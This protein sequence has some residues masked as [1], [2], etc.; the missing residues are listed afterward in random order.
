M[1]RVLRLK[2]GDTATNNDYLG[3]EGEIVLDN[4][5]HTIV[6]HDGVKQG[7]YRLASE[8][9][10]SLG[11]LTVVDQTIAG[12]NIDGNIIISPDGN[13]RV[14]LSN[15]AYPNTDGNAGQTLITDG[16][17]N[18]YWSTP[19]SVTFSTTAPVSPHNGDIWVD[20]NTGIEYIYY[21][22]DDSSQWVEFGPVNTQNDNI[23]FLALNTN[24]VPAVDSFYDLGT[25]SKQWRSLY[26]SGNT[27]YINQIPLTIDNSQNLLVNGNIIGGSQANLGNVGFDGD[28][29]Y[30]INGI[31][32][33]NNDLAHGGTAWVQIP[34]NGGGDIQAENYY[35]NTI[36]SSSLTGVQAMK[37]WTF[38]GD[39]TL[40]L[41][42]INA[43]GQTNAAWLQTTG[44][45]IANANG[46]LFIF[47]DD[48][49]LQ[50]PDGKIGRAHV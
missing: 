8:G 13:G 5:A 41:P 45:I 37:S 31:R 38:G 10:F 1:I 26:V 40:T 17:G 39:G 33:V 46:A 49:S 18:L 43:S 19:S 23:N 28:N 12:T 14:I 3:R 7:G 11:N 42:K 47:A 2:R 44:N 27:I 6:I 9:N 35:G 36:I 48:N 50:F 30:D 32:I 24:V 22:D 25:T 20:S 4:Q 16:N 21:T 15:L 34:A 29:I